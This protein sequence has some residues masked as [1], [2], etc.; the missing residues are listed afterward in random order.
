VGVPE[1]IITGS[2]FEGNQASNGGAVGMLFCGNPGIYNSRFENNAAVGVG[3]NG[4]CDSACVGVGHEEQ[5]GAGGNSGAVYLDGLNDEDKVFNICG[6][7]FRNN[8]AN[9]LGGALFRTPNAGAREMLIDNCV[10]DGNTASLGGVSFIKDH[11]LTVR[12]TTIMNNSADN[13]GGLWVNNGTMDVENCT[14]FNNHPTGLIVDN[15]GTVKNTTIVD[16]PLDGAFTVTNSLFAE[17]TCSSPQAGGNNL[18]WPEGTAC[19]EG[20][21]FADPELGEI[22]DNGGATPTFLPGSAVTGIGAD[23][24]ETDQR[25][26]PRD[27]ASCAAGSVEP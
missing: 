24:P 20:T 5:T 22:A 4:C 13:I 16:S 14:I 2:V 26:E 10:F 27:T 1:L 21:T 3:Q 8:A 7:V 9:E 12:R 15:G 19:A 18:Q 17:M 25:G 23:C 6:S 11:T